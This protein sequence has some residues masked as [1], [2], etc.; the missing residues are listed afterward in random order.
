MTAPADID[1][2]AIE[3]ERQRI[4]NAY[5]RGDRPASSARGVH[6]IALMSSNVEASSSRTAPA[7]N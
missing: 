7:S 3:A 1:L 6:H 4:R 2:D 5:L